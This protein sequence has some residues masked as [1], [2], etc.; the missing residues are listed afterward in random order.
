M[1]QQTFNLTLKKLL[2]DE[3]MNF[4]SPM[5]DIFDR[6]KGGLFPPKVSHYM[7]GLLYLHRKVHYHSLRNYHNNMVNNF[8]ER[9]NIWKS[10]P[11]GEGVEERLRV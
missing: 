10:C 4:I 6:I 1:D 9:H 3:M 5:V 7:E 11:P 8:I 2:R